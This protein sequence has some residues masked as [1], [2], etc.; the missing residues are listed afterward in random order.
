MLAAQMLLLPLMVQGAQ[1]AE[2][3]GYSTLHLRILSTAGRVVRPVAIVLQNERA[4]LRIEVSRPEA[5]DAGRSSG[6]QSSER[7]DE[8]ILKGVPYG[9]YR[10]TVQSPL[11]RQLEANLEIDVAASVFSRSV[12]M[13]VNRPMIQWEPGNARPAMLTVE[14]HSVPESFAWVH[15]RHLHRF[16]YLIEGRL[17]ERGSIEVP[18]LAEGEYVV[19]VFPR[20][21]EPWSLVVRYQ[22]QSPAVLKVNR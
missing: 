18:K 4:G 9:R 11:L 1:Q 6:E 10:L 13:A 21:G 7:F 19:I 16:T 17:D 12:F 3:K 5:S 14:N 15:V 2:R 8:V 22:D 20:R